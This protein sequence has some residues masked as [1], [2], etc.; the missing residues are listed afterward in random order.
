[1]F[2]SPATLAEEAGP[3]TFTLTAQLSGGVAPAGGL[4]VNLSVPSIQ[5]VGYAIIRDDYAIIGTFPSTVTIP[6]GDS[7]AS[8]QFTIEP[9]LDEV[10]DD[11]ERIEF[12]ALTSVP[13]S[14]GGSVNLASLAHVTIADP[15]PPTARAALVTAAAEVL[16]GS[17]VELS[18]SVGP[19]GR[20]HKRQSQIHRP[21]REQ[22]DH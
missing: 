12:R 5:S 18:G 6:A 22:R 7:A 19:T 20:P 10:A 4:P 21:R 3:A 8:A 9:V 16:A 2:V 1:M 11:G 14:S 13:S 17:R 15:K